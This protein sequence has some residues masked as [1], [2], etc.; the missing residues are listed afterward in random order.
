LYLQFFGK[1]DTEQEKSG[2]I[3]KSERKMDNKKTAVNAA[4]ASDYNYF[5]WQG[6]KD[7]NYPLPVLSCII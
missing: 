7:L 3:R 5:P 6:Q 1:S 2:Q 4:I